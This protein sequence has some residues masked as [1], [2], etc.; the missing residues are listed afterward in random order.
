MCSPA[1]SP[2][3]PHSQGLLLK[4]EVLSIPNFTCYIL[5][6]YLSWSHVAQAG[7]EPSMYPRKTLN[8]GSPC[9][10]L[11]SAGVQGGSNFVL[12]VDAGS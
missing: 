3:L 4:K 8:G 2:A 6:L 1:V 10:H 12:F 7:F 5:L 9:L 11:P